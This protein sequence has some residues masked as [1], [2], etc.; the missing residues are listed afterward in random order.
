MVTILD[1]I[2]ISSHTESQGKVHTVL[3]PKMSWPLKITGTNA[4]ITGTQNLELGVL[5]I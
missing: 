5:H 4:N 3:Q 1:R 2:T